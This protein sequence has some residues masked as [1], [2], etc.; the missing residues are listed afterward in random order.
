MK[1]LWSEQ[2]AERMVERYA[3][4][5]VGI[6]LAF[7]TLRHLWFHANLKPLARRSP[8]LVK[9]T[10]HWEIAEAERQ[11]GADVARAL[12]RQAR[13]HGQVR[14]FFSRFDFFVLP[15][16]QVVPFDHAIPFPTEIAGQAMHTYIDW[17]RS[18]WYVSMMAAP[19]IS[20]P[21]GFTRDG[22]PVGLQ[23][24]GRPRDDLS[25]LQLS[26]AFELAAPHGS[27]RPSLTPSAAP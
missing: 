6:D 16:T 14:A 4:Q 18:C 9:D 1:S 2:D 13:F 11:S 20:V 26:H 27:R 15:V 19:A 17:M 21:A 22:L 24:V 25:V 10:I 12:A 5:G 7:E 3:Q 8:E 23:I